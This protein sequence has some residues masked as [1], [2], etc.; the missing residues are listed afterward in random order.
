M[1][2]NS[3]F[4]LFEEEHPMLDDLDEH[5]L[6]SN[7]V[8]LSLLW[9][10]VPLNLIVF[11]LAGA[12]YIMLGSASIGIASLAT[13][14]WLFSKDA[15][16][17]RVT[18]AV[19]YIATI[20]LLLAGMKGQAWQVDI[21]MYYFAALAIL[22]LYC[23]WRVIAAAAATVA[24][25]HLVLNF[26]LPLAVYP[27]GSDFGRV[28]LHALI[29]C[30]E[31]GA[32]IWL[33]Q[34]LNVMFAVARHH[35]EEAR[36]AQAVAE[37]KA[38]AEAQNARDVEESGRRA[39]EALL[40]QVAAEQSQVIDTLAE[41]LEQLAAGDL[42]YRIEDCFA[43]RYEKLR[44]DFH[45]AIQSLQETMLA[46]FDDT[47]EIEASSQQISHAADDLSLQAGKQAAAVEETAAALDEIAAALRQTTEGANQTR[48]SAALAKMDAEKGS[49][50]VR[51]AV[52][53]MSRIDESAREISQIIGVIDEIAFQT[54]LLALNAGVEA[55][56]AGD[57]GRGFAVV[58][59]EVRAL[60]QRSADAAKEI[61]A[62]I[63]TSS[64]Q[65]RSGVG[66]VGE[67]GTALG[68]ILNRISE[69]NT[70]IAA[71]ASAAKDQSVQLDS[72]NQAVGHIDRAT[73]QN[74]AMARDATASNRS[75]AQDAAALM[76]LVSR[77]ELGA[78][79][80]D[81]ANGRY[82]A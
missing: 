29:L 65:V 17:I 41:A 2:R 53:A 5:R 49:Q 40:R 63:A 43:G 47:C 50:I 19:A 60:A 14:V 3:H 46:I 7:Y 42:T 11:V 27:G 62:L 15:G 10:H 8:I 38:A 28:I 57:A 35:F 6:R 1:V 21:H 12:P 51:E 24:L 72:L 79:R 54:N 55:A 23:D 25:H 9:L 64:T 32:L 20:S 76:H 82:A 36:N 78:A 33:A 13:A 30:G 59:S 81:Q 61:K 52:E 18:F 74:A 68:R 16:A 67:T 58:A 66:L 71:M 44:E 69:I 22:G 75:L 31:A 45:K 77:F 56:R 73:Q 34:K 26:V 80:E 70:L 4:V 48:E 37:A 39:Q